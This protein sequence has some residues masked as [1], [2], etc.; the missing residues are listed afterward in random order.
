MKHIRVVCAAKAGN[1]RKVQFMELNTAQTS[2]QSTS[3]EEVGQPLHVGKNAIAT[4]DIPSA[5]YEKQEHLIES[6][7]GTHLPRPGEGI[8]STRRRQVDGGTNRPHFLGGRVS[9]VLN[10]RATTSVRHQLVERAKPNLLW[11]T[12]S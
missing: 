4:K 5:I 2:S 10:W 3:D 8:S 11:P 7:H 9:H 6:D 1:N 12:P